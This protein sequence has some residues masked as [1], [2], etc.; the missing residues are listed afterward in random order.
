MIK[1]LLFIS[2]AFALLG[3]SAC[4]S[5][6]ETGSTSPKK[7]KESAMSEAE[8]VAFERLLFDAFT[9]KALNNSDK[10]KTAFNKCLEID[11]DNP[12]VHYELARLDQ[13]LGNTNSAYDHLQK[14]LEADPE[15]IW[16]NL[17]LA[18]LQF[19]TGK[20]K[21]AISG[22]RKVLKADPSK[23]DVY[24]DI[25]AAQIYS[26]EYKG[27]IET[28]NELEAVVGV[29]EEISLQKHQ[30]YLQLQDEEGAENELIKLS[31]NNPKEIA[32]LGMLLNFYQERNM[33]SKASGVLEKMVA[34]NP[35]D[36]TVQ[37]YLSQNYAQQG[38]EEESFNA[39][40]VA[41]ADP[42]VN[43]DQKVSIMLNYFNIPESEEKAKEQAHE[44]LDIMKEA[45][46]GEAKTYA[47]RGDFF[48]RDGQSETAVEE[49]RKAISIDASRIPLWQQLI[50]IDSELGRMQDMADDAE[51]ATELFPTQP[52]FYL[53]RGIA[54]ERL[55]KHEEAIETLSIG[56]ELVFDMPLLSAEFYSVMGDAHY[57]LKELESSFSSYDRSLEYNPNNAL[58]LNNYA[59]YLSLER[60]KLD[61]AASMAKKANE[62][63]PSQ[64]SFQDTYAWILFLQGDLKGAELLQKRALENGGS[65]NGVILE[66]YG[67]I[68]YKLDRKAEALE[69]WNKA[70]KAGNASSL[71]EQKIVEQKYFDEKP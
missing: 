23:V 5:A 36:G 30:I 6:K 62:L 43:V 71:I 61:K 45:H 49:Y 44:L 42:Q 47:L 57:S 31:D 25:A 35:N 64:A 39:L 52:E 11:P 26:E 55:D 46:P 7:G 48:Y 19:E 15:N 21:E 51:D 22:F 69:Y 24:F 65:Q 53:Y 70:Q 9:E 37:L 16:Y 54:L 58:V 68:L 20:F 13:N 17:F 32:Y 2:I 50:T 18:D 4:S 8:R 12:T 34:L 10:A 33:Q 28:Y 38:K 14:A 1:K 27:A 63:V 56:K 29:S 40:K 60:Q 67:D 41:F 3:L 66:H 59:Y